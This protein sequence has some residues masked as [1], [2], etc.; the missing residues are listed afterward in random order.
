MEKE[1]A[2]AAC[3]VAC[4][5]SVYPMP[6]LPQMVLPY[7]LAGL[8]AKSFGVA[9]WCWGSYLTRHASSHPLCSGSII[10]G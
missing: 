5:S 3:K 8:G 2:A 7:V 10:L 9:G 6:P 1:S 4:C